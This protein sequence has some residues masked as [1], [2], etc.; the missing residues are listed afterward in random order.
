VSRDPGG[1]SLLLLADPLLGSALAQ[2]LAADSR[3]FR[4]ALRPGDLLGRPALVLWCLAG[5]IPW[6]T[7][8]RELA[9]LREHWQPAPI[10]L[11][12][13]AA[14]IAEGQES[15]LMRLS[16]EGLLCEPDDASL[17]AA[18]DTLIA[19]GRILDLPQPADQVSTGGTGFG[20]ALL[21]SGLD[22]IEAE[23]A[24]CQ[25]LGRQQRLFW[26]EEQLLQGRI[27]ELQAARGFLLWIWG[28][29]ALAWPVADG[30]SPATPELLETPEAARSMVITLRTR[31][32]LGVW[33]AIQGR[34]EQAISGGLANGTGQLLAV[35]G[36]APERRRELLQSLLLQLALL[37][38]RF[39]LEEERGEPLLDRW[40]SAQPEL[41]RQALR[42][43]AGSYVQLPQ[44]GTLL[45]VADTLL[46][47]CDLDQEDAELPDPQTM[48]TAL[49]LAQ[50]LLVDGCLVA[51]DEPRAL[52]QLESLVT[53]WLL[54]NA[55]ML[56]A[57]LLGCCGAWPELRRYLLAPPLLAT[58]PLERLRN[59]LNAQQRWADWF[60]RPVQ[61]YESRRELYRL[62]DGVITVQVLT[63]PRDQELARLGWLAQAVTLVLETR[64]ALGPQVRLI[65][66]GFGDVVVVLLTQVIGRAIGLVGRGV[67]Q[68]MGRS[69]SRS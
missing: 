12:L 32:A 27:R 9:L 5:P 66:K 30:P 25:A 18:I 21:A 64:D 69:L 42:Q 1:A 56:S 38:Q 54:R 62:Q 47:R 15:A 31:T 51:P 46:L 26:L 22:Q 17:L 23:L 14:S 4:V 43:L 57:E 63:E 67:L 58:R 29:V 33:E 41:R 65:L 44:A 49:V 39:R 6:P 28:P 11:V 68:G 8:E 36:L 13:T 16:V 2:Q 48:L 45:P 37:L 40:R 35:E 24:Y 3:Q 34:L 61:L 59:Q 20:T 52:L 60:H 10:L 19:G 55:E 50:P 53:N 7:L